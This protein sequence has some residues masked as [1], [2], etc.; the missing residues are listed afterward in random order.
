VHI[1]HP[2]QAPVLIAKRP[3]PH[4]TTNPGYRFKRTRDAIFGSELP[5][6]CPALLRGHPHVGESSP[7]E[8][9]PRLS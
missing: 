6:H 9:H 1:E 5:H 4:T 3:G 8:S 2:T 7:V